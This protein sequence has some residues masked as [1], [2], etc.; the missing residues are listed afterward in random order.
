VIELGMVRRMIRSALVLGP[1]ALVGLGVWGGTMAALS[2]A[3]GIAM[4][5]ANLWLAG[6]IIGGVADN[7]PG[8][9]L[10]AGLLAFGLGLALLTGIAL[11]LQA[12]ELV[13]FPVMGFTLIGAHIVLVGREAARAY[14]V[15]AGTRR[16][17]ASTVGS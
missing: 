8:L 11:A 17:D 5:L 3:V 12:A 9:L 10:V 2:G 7:N 14:P 1:V 6:R 4:A 15:Q 16:D 13:S